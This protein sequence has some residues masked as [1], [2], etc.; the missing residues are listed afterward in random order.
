MDDAN[1]AMSLLVPAAMMRSPL[2]A[3]ACAIVKRSSTVMIFPFDNTITTMYLSGA[4][5]FQMYD[6]VA[7]RS[8]SRGCVSQAQIAG[9]RIRERNRTA[10]RGR[11]RCARGISVGHREGA[12]GRQVCRHDNS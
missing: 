9:S 3:T 10:A 4:E 7:R 5:V 1:R 8:A 2:I 6:F 12:D 11:N